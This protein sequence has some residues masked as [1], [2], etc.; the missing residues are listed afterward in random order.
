MTGA[1]HI[2]AGVFTLLA[3]GGL[4]YQLL[5]IFAALR[6][7]RWRKSPEVA[8]TPAISILKPLKGFDPE[9]YESFRSHCMQDYSGKVEIIFGVNDSC[10]P[11]VEAVAQLRQEFPN[12]DISLIVCADVL[13][14]NRKIS[15]LVQM[16]ARAKY[17]HVVV[18]DSDIRVPEDYLRRVSAYFADPQ[19]GMVTALYRG[20]P[21]SGIW[22]KLEAVTIA[23]DFAGGVLSA[24][25]VE[26][27]LHF[28]LGSTLAI[29]K[30]VLAKIGGFEGLCDY[31]ADDYELGNR[32]SNVGYRVA[33]AD[34]VV[35]TFLP[36]Y[37]VRG[38]F[39]HQLRWARTIRDKRKAG[40]VGVLFTFG[41]VW[42]TVAAVLAG[43]V[44]WSLSVLLAVAIARF[45]GAFLLCARVLRDRISLRNLWLVPL[46][47]A[48]GVLVWLASF[49]GDTV[50]W[51]GE[52]FRLHDG[53][54]THVR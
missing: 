18:N 24:M 44:W 37:G 6:Y 9:M 8:L 5:A 42:A 21:H 49:A 38:M 23:T 47:D 28:A 52:R 13:G 3:I 54:L 19:V 12:C 35:E 45:T 30:E 25:V 27:G 20:V 39:D 15:N 11:A 50:D 51:R 17:D 33:L 53:K 31:L 1:L 10:D 36:A 22:S 14:T 32:T 34:V 40:Y 29:R 7:L 16:S 48:I 4:G 2:A 46:R 41:L 43:G 26:G